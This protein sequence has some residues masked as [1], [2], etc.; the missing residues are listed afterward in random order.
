MANGEAVQLAWV[1]NS[2]F[3]MRQLRFSF[4]FSFFIYSLVHDEDWPELCEEYLGSIGMMQR[5]PTM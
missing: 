2:F 1:M 5:T 3:I 4:S